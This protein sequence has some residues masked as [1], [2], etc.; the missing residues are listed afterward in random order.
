MYYTTVNQE[1]LRFEDK[2]FCIYK[3]VWSYPTKPKSRKYAELN[4]YKEVCTDEFIFDID[5]AL[6]DNEK[7]AIL[8][9]IDYTGAIET[10][11]NIIKWFNEKYPSLK[12]NV[13]FS[14]RKGFHISIKFDRYYNF[15]TNNYNKTTNQVI[16]YNELV[17]Q[18]NQ[19][20]ELI[21]VGI[22]NGISQVNRL[23][24]LP[25]R[26]KNTDK[27]ESLQHR[28]FKICVWNTDKELTEFPNMDEVINAS[29]RNKNLIEPITNNKADCEDF[30][31]Y[32]DE[33]TPTEEITNNNKTIVKTKNNKVIVTNNNLKE[34]IK[35]VLDELESI[36]PS[37]GHKNVRCPII[38]NCMAY[39]SEKSMN[40][41]IDILKTTG[42]GTDPTNTRQDL[43][44]AY[45]EGKPNEWAVYHGLGCLDDA[46]LEMAL[47]SLNSQN[48][49]DDLENKNKKRISLFN[50]FKEELELY[51]IN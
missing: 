31:N 27:N 7:E 51:A 50:T 5:M 46:I 4:Q 34:I 28:G 16:A 10:V 13:W 11:I 39:L 26:R 44:N 12:I 3:T 6:S 32:L 37:D 2:R 48:E 47:D 41:V 21:G 17:K 29:K 35:P 30:I 43:E 14:G 36:H 42:R 24:Q 49:K 8:K 25:N 23:I 45:R 40:E 19:E 1:Y 38:Y 9:D 18:L 22:D 20:I 33:L 15:R